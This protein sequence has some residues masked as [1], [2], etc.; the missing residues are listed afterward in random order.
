[1]KTSSKYVMVYD[2]ETGGLPSEKK[3]PFLDIAIVEMS[4]V[5][6]DMEILSIVE[7]KSFMFQRDYKDGLIYT[8]EA[9]AVHGVSKEMQKESGIPLKDIFKEL[10]KM[11]GK[12]K[13]PRQKCTVCGHNATGFDFPFLVEFFSFM[14][15]DINEYVKFQIDTM[16][17]CHMAAVEQVDY[18]LRTCCN[19][20]GI[21]LV[22]AHRALDDTRA[23]A[24]LFIELIKKLRN[25]GSA[26]TSSSSN[27]EERFRETFQI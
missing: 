24:L 16:Q 20:H 13:N 8:P 14:K 18:T 2:L 22:N 6:V 4:V 25:E 12:Y 15:S 26:V 1:M 23:N 27:T 19:I 5:V 9:E 10:V 11:F 21:D 3:L 7:E 17:M